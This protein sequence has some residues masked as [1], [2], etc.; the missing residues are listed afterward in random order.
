MKRIDS[1]IIGNRKTRKKTDEI[2]EP[3]EVILSGKMPL[4]EIDKEIDRFRKH[5]E[6]FAIILKG[7]KV[8]ENKIE[9][10]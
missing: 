8:A 3:S 10:E 2:K 1:F 6:D 7:G 4:I 5:H 9:R